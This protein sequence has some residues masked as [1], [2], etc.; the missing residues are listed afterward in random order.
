MIVRG[1]IQTT[2]SSIPLPNIPL[3]SLRPFFNAKSQRRQD[4]KREDALC[5]AIPKNCAFLAKFFLCALC[6]S[7]RCTGQGDLVAALPRCAS[8]SLRLCVENPAIMR[9]EI[10]PKLREDF[11]T[12]FRISRMKPPAPLQFSIRDLGHLRF[13]FF[14]CGWPRCVF[15]GC[16]NCRFCIH[17]PPA[18]I[19]RTSSVVTGG[20][21][22]GNRKTTRP[23]SLQEWVGAVRPRRSRSNTVL[24]SETR[25][26]FACRVTRSRMSS[27]KFNVVLMMTLRF[28]RLSRIWSGCAGRCR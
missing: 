22:V 3:T 7:A 25:R 4:A 10:F 1:I 23:P 28:R 21:S 12:D 8:A 19:L 11:A 15:Y 20:E 27:S 9:G 26:S 24:L 17:A 5:S 13:S 6:A 18:S 14:D 2:P 16:F